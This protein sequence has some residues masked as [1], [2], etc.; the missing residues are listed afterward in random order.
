MHNSGMT[1]PSGFTARYICFLVILLWGFAFMLAC[2]ILSMP[3]RHKIINRDFTGRM[4]GGIRSEI[5]GGL[6]EQ[7]DLVFH[8]GVAHAPKTGRLDW[9]AKMRQQVA[10]Y[11]HF[12][13]HKEGILE[14]MPW[15][16]FATRADPNNVTAY[17]V[18]A[19]WLAGEAGRPDLAEGVLNEAIRNN[20][21]DYRVYMEKGRLAMKQ[22]QYKKAARLLDA[23][24]SRLPGTTSADK[25]QKR[26]DCA[27]I[28]VYRGLMYEIQGNPKGAVRCYHE[29]LQL[30]PGRLNLKERMVQLEKTGHSPT[31]PEKLAETL[32]FKHRLVCAHEEDK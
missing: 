13:L 12:H 5:S 4:L 32:L 21:S 31:P 16:Y 6:Y 11:G 22:G 3:D 20:P 10:P 15:L 29:I 24:Y 14:I 2:R 8:K 1:L 19:Y 26:S 30:F 28:L 25:D 18:A 23:A 27:E 17:A 7:A 9:F